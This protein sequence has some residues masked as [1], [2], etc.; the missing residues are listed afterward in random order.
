MRS[1]NRFRVD[2]EIGCRIDGKSVTASLYNLS[3][4]G[5]MI[6]TTDAAAQQ[7][8]E[9]GVALTDKVQMPGRIVWRLGKNAGVKFDLPLHQKVVEHFGYTQEEDFDRDDPRDRFGIP[10][11]EIREQAAGMIE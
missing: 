10:L 7:G 4:G 11:V 8:A 1:Y 2:Q 5:C 6:E 3:S 9:V